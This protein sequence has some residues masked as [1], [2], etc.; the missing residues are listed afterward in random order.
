MTDSKHIWIET[1]YEIFATRGQSEIKIERLAKIVGK[2]KSSFYHHFADLD[3]FIGLLLDYHIEKS[4][5]IAQK[6]RDAKNI[7]PELITIMLEHRVDLLFSRQLQINQNNPIFYE[8]L[9]KSSAII[10]DAF[11]VVWVKSLNIKLTDKQVDGILS[12]ALQ[13][14][15]LQINIETLNYN[16]LSEYFL[17]LKKISDSFI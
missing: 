3:L 14:F 4:Y 12:L 7:D 13:N 2:S 17:N 15:Y 6:E 9:C 11:K 5:L 8:T 16:W 1:G 10:G